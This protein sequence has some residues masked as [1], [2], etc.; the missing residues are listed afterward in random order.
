MSKSLLLSISIAFLVIGIG[1]G[2]MLSPYYSTMDTD[3]SADL[4]VADR[5]LDLRYINKMT[6]HH[7]SAILIAEEAKRYSKN[8]SILEIANMII[9]N[10]PK[11]IEELNTWK[12]DWYKDN[13]QVEAAEIP[14]L[15]TADRNFDLRFINALIAHH[16]EGIEMAKDAQK[17]STRN[18]VLDN[19]SIVKEF[20]KDSVISLEQLRLNLYNI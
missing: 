20:L 2:F 9:T 19:A 6:A 1:I 5:Y 17:K 8:T 18:E 16:H 7:K 15:G 10:E 12:K 13:S 11:L 14:N 3:H 4:G